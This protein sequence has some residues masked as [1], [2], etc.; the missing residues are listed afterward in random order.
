M[1][2]VDVSNHTEHRPMLNKWRF[3]SRTNYDLITQTPTHKH[4]MPKC[5]IRWLY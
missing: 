2:L 1:F 4:V 5:I 3:K